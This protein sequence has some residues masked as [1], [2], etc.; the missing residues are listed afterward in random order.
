MKNILIIII[1]IFVSSFVY[2]QDLN[3]YEEIIKDGPRVLFIKGSGGDYVSLSVFAG[4]GENKPGLAHLCEHLAFASNSKMKGGDFDRFCE[5]LGTTCDAYTNYDY[6]VYKLIVRKEYLPQILENLSYCLLSNQVRE[7]EFELEKSIINDE[8]MG[9]SSDA[10]TNI[11]FMLQKALY[12]KGYYGY[13]IEGE[14][15][16]DITLEDVKSFY[17]NNY[18]SKNLSIVLYGDID[19]NAT[20][21]TIKRYWTEQNKFFFNVPIDV[22]T[23]NKTIYI[24][25]SKNSFG[26]MFNLAPT[27]ITDEAISCDVLSQLTFNLSQKA[28]F[29]RGRID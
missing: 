3:V 14:D 28:I 1:L 10:M 9:K 20:L 18:I 11:R 4:I 12:G 5:S 21:N 29:R 25:G 24:T 27:Y 23:Y 22:K 13:P 17:D 19:Q 2:C 15:I 7:E 26:I 16:S 6:S 8:Y